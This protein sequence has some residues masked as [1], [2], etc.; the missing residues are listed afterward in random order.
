M[1]QN[2]FQSVHLKTN[3]DIKEKT[4]HQTMRDSSLSSFLNKLLESDYRHYR[5]HIDID[6]SEF[7]SCFEN[8]DYTAFC[9]PFLNMGPRLSPSALATLVATLGGI[10]G[11][12]LIPYSKSS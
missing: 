1:G 12:G 7:I 9:S 4:L 5:K 11:N 6:L 2:N 3:F 8:Q 10:K